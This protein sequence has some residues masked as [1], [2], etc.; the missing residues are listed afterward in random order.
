MYARLQLL[1]CYVTELQMQCKPAGIG[2]MFH[3][4][5]PI[6]FDVVICHLWGWVSSTGGGHLKKLRISILTYCSDP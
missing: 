1:P 2:G 4:K 5:D 6:Q 3:R